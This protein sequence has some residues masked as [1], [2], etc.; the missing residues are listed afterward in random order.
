M[1]RIIV[2]HP[3]RQHSYRLASALKK[4][5]LLQYYVTTIYHGEHPSLLMRVVKKL[6]SGDDLKRAN[7]RTNLNLCKK[8]VIQYNELGGMLEALLVRIDSRH[9]IYE[10]VREHNAKS[11][12]I[13]VAKLAIREHADAVIMYNSNAASGFKYLKIHAPEII[14]IMDV[15][16]VVI[17]YRKKLFEEIFH[18]PS[19]TAAPR[20]KNFFWKR[21][22]NSLY[23]EEIDLADFF[24]VPS[25]FVKETLT[26]CGVAQDK[27]RIVPYGANLSSAVERGVKS[28]GERINFLYAGQVSMHK[29]VPY[30]LKAM[31]AFPSAKAHLTLTGKYYPTDRFVDPYLNIEN[32]SFTGLVTFDRMKSIY[33]SADVFVFPSLYEGMAQVGIE[34]MACGLPIICTKNSGVS[35]LVEEGV[36][37]FV[38]PCA[39]VEAIREKMQWFVDHPDRIREMGAAARETAKKYTWDA[40]N[41]NVVKTLQMILS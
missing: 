20:K 1:K 9:R 26:K 31:S 5:G 30:I 10:F 4:A 15:S 6:L 12:G 24:L 32:I 29:G 3:G 37:G 2:A 39:D 18:I 11:F 7:S 28:K 35:D 27:I 41:E 33:E 36:N 22:S 38:I 13:K 34:A 8:D 17:P 19:E 21:K 16:N 25:K 23:Q 14:C 40:Y